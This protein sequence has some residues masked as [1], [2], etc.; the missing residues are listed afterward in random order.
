[1]PEGAARVGIADIEEQAIAAAERTKARS[2][3]PGGPPSGIFCLQGRYMG[4]W[5]Q[6]WS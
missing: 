6:L 5:V 4:N 2:G 1:V 3:G